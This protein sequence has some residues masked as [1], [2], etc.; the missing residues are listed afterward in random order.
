MSGEVQ[1]RLAATVVV[2]GLLAMS[3]DLRWAWQ[4]SPYDQGAGWM[5][6]IWLLGVALV[7]LKKRT[8]PAAGFILGAVAAGLVAFVGELNV[9]RHAA[10]VLGCVAWLPPGGIRWVAGISGVCWWPA[11]GWAAAQFTGPGGAVIVRF[12]LLAVGVL[13]LLRV[14]RAQSEGAVA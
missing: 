6:A 11:L 4:H 14:G 13:A 12:V 8:V 9:A 2:A 7:A 10:L 1:L 5:A 3:S